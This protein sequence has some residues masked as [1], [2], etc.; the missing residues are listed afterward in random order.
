[1]SA[2]A[3]S[4]T[5]ADQLQNLHL[6]E[7]TG[8]KVSKTELKK[9]QKQRAQDEKKREKLAA[10][11]PKAAAPKK[12]SAEEEESE[13]TPNVRAPSFVFKVNITDGGHSSNT[14]RS[15]L[16]MSISSVRPRIPI[17]IRINS[18]SQQICETS[19]ETTNRSKRESI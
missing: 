9:R 5:A 16:V 14:L 11:P 15:G 4:S 7:V 19:Y 3:G 2:E 10:A 17:P 6:D 12:N 18:M 13:L 8:E 1:M